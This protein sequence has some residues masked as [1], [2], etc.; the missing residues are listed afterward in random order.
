MKIYHNSRCRKSR[1]TLKILEEKNIKCEIINYLDSPP[2]TKE[3]E[4]ILKKLKI[5][6][7][8]LVRKN[9]KIWKEKY[10]G[11]I[12]T[13]KKIINILIKNPKLIERPIVI[14]GTK[15]IIGRPPENVYDLFD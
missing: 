6:P 7:I 9:E 12:L 8:D 10:K 3:I 15:A 14:N 2:S 11:I 13:N 4:L 5:Q 1:D